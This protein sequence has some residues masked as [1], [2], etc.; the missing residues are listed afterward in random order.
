MKDRMTEISAVAS[1]LR[2]W[3]HGKPQPIRDA[4]MNLIGNLMTFA[5]GRAT[6]QLYAVIEQNVK[7]L[8]GE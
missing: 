1:A 6:P 5:R 3:R 2:V 4:A 7:R 8:G